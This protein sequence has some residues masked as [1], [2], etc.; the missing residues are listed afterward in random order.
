MGTQERRERQRDEVRTK[1]MDAARELFAKQGVE[2]VSM[3]KIAEA[4]EYSPT[5]IYLHFADK[6]ALLEQLCAHDFDALAYTF[7]EAASIKDPIERIKALGYKFM[8]FGLKYPNHFRFMFMTPSKHEK[9]IP[10]GQLEKRGDPERDSYAQLLHAVQEAMAAGRFR[11]ELKDENLVAQTF[12][13]AVNGVVALQIGMGND[14]WIEW[15]SLEKRM[16]T[17]LDAIMRGMTVRDNRKV[18]R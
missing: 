5:A 1:I 6:D 3:R 8:K 10:P 15:A 11:P 16:Q 2:A 14:A 12:A 4:I 9:G 7:R 13:A 18:R 17:M